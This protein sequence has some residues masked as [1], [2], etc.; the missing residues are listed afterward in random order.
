MDSQDDLCDFTMSDLALN[1]AR[2][3]G[4]SPGQSYEIGLRRRWRP[5]ARRPALKEI[6]RLSDEDFRRFIQNGCQVQHDQTDLEDELCRLHVQ[7]EE[8]KE[9]VGA[10]VRRMNGPPPT[11]SQPETPAT[12]TAKGLDVNPR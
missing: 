8:L 10:V 6:L 1:E 3:V 5:W 7:L 2:R 9:I 11:R 4:S 12:R